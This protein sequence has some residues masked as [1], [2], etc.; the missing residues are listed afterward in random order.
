MRERRDGGEGEGE[1]RK[2]K[3]KLRGGGKKRKK[4]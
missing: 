3:G 4:I 1:I 2:K